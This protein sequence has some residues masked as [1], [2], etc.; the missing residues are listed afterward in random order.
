MN[1]IIWIVI[2]GVIGWLASMVMKTNA[3]QG[4]F[5]NIVVGI[6]GAFLGGWLLAPL[7]GTG[8]INSDNFSMSS[9]LVSFLGAVILLGIVNLLRRGKIR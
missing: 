2:G 1:F 7:F 3:Q 9:L 6:V 8:T 4:I 5:L